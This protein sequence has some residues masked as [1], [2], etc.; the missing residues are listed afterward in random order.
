MTD[1][2]RARIETAWND[3]KAC[4]T[5]EQPRS[6]RAILADAESTM[7][8]ALGMA[9]R[10]YGSIKAEENT[11][12]KDPEPAKDMTCAANQLAD[13]ARRLL[14]TLNMIAVALGI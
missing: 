8:D 4:T 1:D 11:L 6:V 10:I 13:K 2:L 3:A 9:H 12:V 14:D 5:M 7:T